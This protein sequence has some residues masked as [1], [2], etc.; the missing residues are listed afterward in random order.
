MGNLFLGRG[1]ACCNTH[2]SC[3]IIVSWNDIK[4]IRGHARVNLQRDRDAAEVYVSEA[5]GRKQT[6][7]IVRRREP[8]AA[9]K[10]MCAQLHGETI[11][12]GIR[13]ITTTNS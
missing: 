13:F 1:G 9:R 2:G 6:R 11:V 5:F 4:L 12:A 10:N 8:L 7:L 3:R